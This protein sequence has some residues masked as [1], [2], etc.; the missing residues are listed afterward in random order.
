M[1]YTVLGKTVNLAARL[2][3]AAPAGGVLVAEETALLIQDEFVCKA[4]KPVS[5]KGFEHQIQAQL[6]EGRKT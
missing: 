6:V 5:A 2:E 3:A 4:V 1:D